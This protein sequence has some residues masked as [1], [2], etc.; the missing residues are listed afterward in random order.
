MKK[1]FCAFFVFILALQMTSYTEE[2]YLQVKTTFDAPFQQLTL[3]PSWTLEDHDKNSISFEHR[4]DWDIEFSI[5]AGK[6][7]KEK[8]TIKKLFAQLTKAE[9]NLKHIPLLIE[10]FPEILL[11]ELFNIDV[12]VE[13][14]SCIVMNGIPGI[15][16]YYQD[17]T[18]VEEVTQGGTAI[19]SDD[20]VLKSVYY[21][22]IINNRIYSL[23]FEAP[24]AKFSEYEAFFEATIEKLFR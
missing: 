21:I 7:L 18:I 9:G 3:D 20:D 14:Y 17:M 23:E 16:A 19:E 24:V 15:K 8:A 10:S 1:I 6:V 11:L 5:E 2:P 12:T 4:D 22:F 13:N